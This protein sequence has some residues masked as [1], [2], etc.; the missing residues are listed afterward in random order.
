MYEKLKDDFDL[1]TTYTV[2]S[3]RNDFWNR[4][5]ADVNKRFTYF[6]PSKAAWNEM[7]KTMPSEYKQLVEGMLPVHGEYVSG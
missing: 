1:H 3:H 7:R 6:A 5:M 2:G 4:K